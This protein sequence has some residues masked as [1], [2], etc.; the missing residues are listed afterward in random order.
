MPL[1]SMKRSLSLIS[2]L[3]AVGRVKLKAEEV[4]YQDSKPSVALW[5]PAPSIVKQPSLQ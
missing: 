1:C 5:I 2:Y 4:F 3:S